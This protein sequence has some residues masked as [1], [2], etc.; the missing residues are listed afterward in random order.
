[1]S[2]LLIFYEVKFQIVVFVKKQE[3]F[4]KEMVDYK[5]YKSP[6]VLYHSCS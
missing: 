2:R 3:K 1:M 4:F 5:L 6:K